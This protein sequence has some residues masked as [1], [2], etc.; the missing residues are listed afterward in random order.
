VPQTVSFTNQGQTAVSIHPA[1]KQTCNYPYV[2]PPAPGVV[3]GL[4]VVY[5][6]GQGGIPPLG[7][8]DLDGTTGKPNFPIVSDDCSGKL[9]MPQDSCEINIAFSPQALAEPVSFYFDNYFLELNTQGEPDS[10][11][12]P[13]E[14][15]AN[16]PSVLRMSPAAGIA[17]GAQP[18]G[19]TSA[20]QTITLSNSSTNAAASFATAFFSSNTD[21]VQTNNCGTSLAPGASC[22][23]SVTFTPNH[24]GYDAAKITITTDAASGAQQFIY[25]RGTGQ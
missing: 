18:V 12:F 13:V 4:Q 17:F 19:T 1:L 25:L 22:T 5:L 16:Q 23:I 3:P 6:E 11:R 21:Y 10:G 14:L 7:A 9:L 24:T 2:Y 15:K 8:C 20:A